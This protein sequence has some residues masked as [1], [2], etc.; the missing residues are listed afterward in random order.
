MAARDERN[1]C[2]VKRMRLQTDFSQEVAESRRGIDGQRDGLF[3]FRHPHLFK[4]RNQTIR[5]DGRVRLAA[6]RINERDR[7]AFEVNVTEVDFCL[8][9]AAT[10][11]QRDTESDVTPVLFLLGKLGENLLDL[12]VREFFLFFGRLATDAH[13]QAGISACPLVSNG[14]IHQQA[15]YLDVSEGR[16]LLDLSFRHPMCQ[17]PLDV[18]EAVDMG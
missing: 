1:P 14:V 18:V 10:R 16:R 9:Q 13:A 4:H 3:R 12:L 6:F 11:F 5:Q 8:S 7:L 17:T 15:E 2:A